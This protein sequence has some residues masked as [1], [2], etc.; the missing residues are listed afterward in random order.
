[1][2]ENKKMP[3]CYQV[4]IIYQKS[5]NINTKA[6]WSNKIDLKQISLEA[7]FLEL[8]SGSNN[9]KDLKYIHGDQNNHTKN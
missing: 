2:A 9:N 7:A 1:M 3:T 6:L 4:D 5:Q 8:R